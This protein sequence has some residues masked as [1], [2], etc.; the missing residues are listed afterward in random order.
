MSSE[1]YAQQWIS[2]NT[3]ILCDLNGLNEM[4]EFGMF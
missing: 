1:Q 2:D 3:V 4:A